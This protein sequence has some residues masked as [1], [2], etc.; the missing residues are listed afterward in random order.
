[1]LGSHR[2]L[3]LRNQQPLQIKRI[4]VSDAA[5]SIALANASEFSRVH[6]FATRY[7]P[8]YR[9]LRLSRTHP[10][11]GAVANRAGRLRIVLRGRTQAGRRVPLHH[12]PQVR[13]EIPRQHAEAAQPAAQSVGHPRHGDRAAAGARGRGVRSGSTEQRGGARG[14]RGPAR[15][16]PPNR[17]SRPAWISWPTAPPCW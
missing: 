17:C 4:A 13:G 7:E 12:R 8:A 10:G 15:P 16:R 1:M 2:Q 9:G 3:E 5:L 14:R 6:V 11:S